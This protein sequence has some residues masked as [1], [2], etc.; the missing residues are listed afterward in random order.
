MNVVE[1]RI[2]IIF[3]IIFTVGAVG[4][5]VPALRSLVVPLTPFTIL[6]AFI[7]SIAFE[8]KISFGFVA[9]LVCI[10][11]M[12]FFVEYAG[13]ETG[14]IFGVYQYGPTLGI[15]WNGIP[16]LIG[17]NWMAVILFANNWSKL[18]IK[19]PTIAAFVGA[20]IAAGFDYIIEPVAQ[21]YN[22]WKWQYGNIPL[23]NYI[24]WFVVALLFSIL[25]QNTHKVIKN[26]IASGIF[27]LEILF[28]A[29]I[30]IY[31]KFF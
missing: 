30:F 7:T 18:Y 23:Q 2:F 10:G 5:I 31:L 22:F 29:T 13:V 21:A 16:F 20:I 17:V 11:I 14:K 8:K 6:A 27:L 19:N 12:G 9:S 24:A 25:Y 1:K 15:K 4:F 3:A 28:F 26:R